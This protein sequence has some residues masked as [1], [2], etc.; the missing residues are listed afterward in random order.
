M[1]KIK[2]LERIIEKNAEWR[3]QDRAK[4]EREEIYLRNFIDTS[5]APTKKVNDFWCNNCQ[6]DFRAV[7]IKALCGQGR[8]RY[9]AKCVCGKKASRRITEKSGDE[10]Y[11]LS[12]IEKRMRYEAGDDLLQPS[13]PR[14]EKVWGHKWKQHE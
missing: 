7:G 11:S 5:K 6:K 14:F 3:E 1:E 12:A 9:D 8:S 13:D 2:R 4:K 10:Y